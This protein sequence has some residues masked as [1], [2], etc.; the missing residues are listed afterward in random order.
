MFW[1]RLL[2]DV[3]GKLTFGL[4]NEIFQNF[5]YVFCAH[6]TSPFLKLKV[7]PSDRIPFM[8]AYQ[9]TTHENNP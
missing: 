3:F 4:E 2:P 8:L 7:F 6:L 5:P 9:Q 1:C